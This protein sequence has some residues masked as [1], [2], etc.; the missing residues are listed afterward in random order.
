MNEVKTK[1]CRFGFLTGRWM[2]R[3]AMFSLFAVMCTS[4]FGCAVAGWFASLFPAADLPAEYELPKD[5]AVLVLVEDPQNVVSYTP[6]K[7]ELARSINKLLEEHK[8]CSELISPESVLHIKSSCHDYSQLSTAEIGKKL[9]ADLVIYVQITEFQLKD[10]Q[11]DPVWNG[12]MSA[13]VR[14]ISVKEGRLW[15][16]DTLGGFQVSDVVRD[17]HMDTSENYME[18]F[19]AEMAKE[20]AKNIAELFYPHPAPEHTDIPKKQVNSLNEA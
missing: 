17:R 16:K 2:K 6:I 12:K 9:D 11:Y 20:L 14:V 3:L 13:T 5:Q 4:F 7:Y 8:A 1:K 18:K 15:P 19:S 10:S